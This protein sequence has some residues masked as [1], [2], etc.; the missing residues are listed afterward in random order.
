MPYRSK[1]PESD[2][3]EGERAPTR[4]PFTFGPLYTPHWALTLEAGCAM[5]SVLHGDCWVVRLEY[6]PARLSGELDEHGEQIY[7]LDEDA[8]RRPP[9]IVAFGDP[10]ESRESVEAAFLDALCAAWC[11]LILRFT[12]IVDPLDAMV[13]GV[14]NEQLADVWSG[15]EDVTH[16]DLLGMVET[17][18]ERRQQSD[19]HH[20]ERVPARVVDQFWRSKGQ[21]YGVHPSPELFFRLQIPIW[22]NQCSTTDRHQVRAPF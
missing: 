20:V 21:L 4:G 12:G 15:T 5:M 22:R 8:G 10:G 2:D 6:D 3:G 18:S 17:C 13:G 16:Y 1:L 7:R 9:L 14:V 11:A 19:S